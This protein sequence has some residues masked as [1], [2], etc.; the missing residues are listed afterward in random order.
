MYLPRFT[1]GDVWRQVL[2]EQGSELATS[3]NLV[4]EFR[5]ERERVDSLGLAHS[6]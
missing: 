3:P 4:L 5:L 1:D 2:A 6:A